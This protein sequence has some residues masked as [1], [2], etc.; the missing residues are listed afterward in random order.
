MADFQNFMNRPMPIDESGNAAERY[1]QEYPFDYQS[2]YLETVARGWEQ[3][4]EQLLKHY[5]KIKEEALTGIVDY[6]NPEDLPISF[7]SGGIAGAIKKA[8]TSAMAQAGK[9][10]ILDN[11]NFKKWFGNSKVVDESGKPL[12]VYHGT[13]DNIKSFDLNHPNRKDTGWLG[14]GVY[15]T[16]SPSLA[17]DYSLL[18]GGSSSPN[19]LPVHA[20]LEN[21]YYA[22]LADKERLMLKGKRG[23]EAAD[24]WTEEL[25]AK[26]HD[27]VILQYLAKDV[28]EKN[29]SREIV[30]FDP[31]QIKSIFNRGTYDPKDPDLLHAFM[32]PKLNKE[33]D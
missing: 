10:N 33:D 8:G 30:V 27:G 4:E 14:R 19:V 28:G 1:I 24:A 3:N 16:D 6:E 15:L 20:K 18:K 11:P 9:P 29:V 21:P 23:Q 26:G 12:T 31:K 25:K 13:S 7:D 2:T 32:P 22:T 5:N 17:S